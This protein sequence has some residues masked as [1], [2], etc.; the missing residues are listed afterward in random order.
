MNVRIILAA[1][2]VVAGPA[3]SQGTF[4]F[5]PD[6]RAEEWNTII[7]ITYTGSE[8]ID[9]PADLSLS[10]NDDWGF[11]FGLAYNFT[12]H[13]A[14]GFEFNFSSPRYT[15]TGTPEGETEPQTLSHKMNVFSGL[16]R[17]TWHILSGNFTPFIDVNA[18]FAYLDSNVKDGPSYCYP[19]WYW[20]WVCFSSTYSDTRFTYGGAAGLRWDITRG[21]FMRASYGI[22]L[23]DVSN[24]SDPQFNNARVDFGWRY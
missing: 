6:E 8:F 23:I 10:I 12:N 22:Q 17:G 21:F 16:V 2:V 18:G 7:N 9:G 3:W 20:G 15:L 11:G 4:Q 5:G 24:T 14:L 1:L 13:L 19:D